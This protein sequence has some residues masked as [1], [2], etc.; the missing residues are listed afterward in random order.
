MRGKAA[1]AAV[2]LAAGIGL[3]LTAAAMQH[4]APVLQADNWL[5]NTLATGHASG[6]SL[7][8]TAAVREMMTALIAAGHGRDDHSALVTHHERLSGT[9]LAGD[10][11]TSQSTAQK[12]LA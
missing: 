1:I 3:A 8:L 10:Q 12:D 4:P 6:A 9:T 5:I 11:P 7:P 2:L